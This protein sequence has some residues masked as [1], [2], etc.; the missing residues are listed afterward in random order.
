ME[1]TAAIRGL[2]AVEGTSEV[3]L[4]TDSQ[5]VCKGITE[6]IKNWKIKKWKTSSGKLVKNRDLWEILDFFCGRYRVEW[7]WI[8]GHAGNPGNERADALANLA[9]DNF[10]ESKNTNKS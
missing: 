6:W 1:L 4:Y 3:V 7:R 8:R 2:Q 10:L 5:Y 9:I